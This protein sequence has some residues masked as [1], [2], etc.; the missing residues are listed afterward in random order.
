MVQEKDQFQTP[1]YLS[2]ELLLFAGLADLQRANAIVLDPCC[3]LGQI[4]ITASFFGL[5]SLG[6]EI[7]ERFRKNVEGLIGVD[8]EIKA[9]IR[10]WY[11]I[12]PVYTQKYPEKANRTFVVTNVP[13]SEDVDIIETALEQPFLGAVALMPLSHLAGATRRSDFW[14]KYPAEE[15][16][17]I[18]NRI[19]FLDPRGY[20][21]DTTGRLD[22]MM[23]KWRKSYKGPTKLTRMKI[24]A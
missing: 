23:A 13:F 22:L 16:R 11:A 7:D 14:G 8:V 10:D 4:L 20:P 1:S 2:R 6:F 24:Y 12:A 19:E 18:E 9:F 17:V 5:H 15:I 21:S 3:G